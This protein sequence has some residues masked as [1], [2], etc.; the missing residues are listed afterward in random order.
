MPRALP[1]PTPGRDF[2]PTDP[3]HLKGYIGEL[4]LANLVHAQGNHFVVHLGN[5]PGIQGPDV[6][7]IGPDG[8]FMEWDSKA[9]SAERSV[10]PGMAASGSLDRQQL[11]AYVEREIKSG[12]LPP[13]LGYHALRE[14]DDGNYNVCTVGTANAHNGYIETI[15]GRRTSGPRRP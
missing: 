7:S 8:R 9:R 14:F 12:R 13:E 5:P 4:E 2:L 3:N 11:Q 15:R 1:D 6:L 10:G